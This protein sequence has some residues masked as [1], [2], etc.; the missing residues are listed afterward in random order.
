MIGTGSKETFLGESDLRAIVKNA[1]EGNFLSGKRV[2]VIIPDGTRT[3]PMPL[4]FRLLQEEWEP[5]TNAFDFLVALGTH[6]PMSDAQLSRHLGV[7]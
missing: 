4:M 1:G 7:E 6:Q 3:M 2:L 5:Q